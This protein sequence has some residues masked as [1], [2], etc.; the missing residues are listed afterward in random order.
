M[1]PKN[2][3]KNTLKNTKSA[4]KADI[5]S[6]GAVVSTDFFFAVVVS[7]GL[8]LSW[9]LMQN[10]QSISDQYA[11]IESPKAGVGNVALERRVKT[12]V[13]GFPIERMTPYI[14]QESEETAAFLV[15]IA[16][17]ESNWGKR[18]PKKDGQDC[19]NYWGYRG[20]GDRVTWDGYT[21]FDSPKQ[22]IKT[23]GHR[24]DTLVVQ[25]ELDTPREIVVW[26]CGWTCAGHNS[27]G[28][29]KWIQ[30]VDYYY[31]KVKPET[32]S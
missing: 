19:F 32:D 23:V 24:I 15:G 9:L 13:K 28:V 10:A 11:A 29:E 22:A 14:S 12:L 6:D 1:K 8:G 4:P 7:I 20:G 27:A 25:H 18:V 3:T 21:C 2:N 31:H 26:K 17:K 30:D 5:F 16:K